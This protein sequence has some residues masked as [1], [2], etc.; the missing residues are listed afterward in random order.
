M[1]H[2]T[3]RATDGAKL[4]AWC[5]EL[6]R[7]TAV[8]RNRDYCKRSC[9]QRAY[10]AR[11]QREAVVAAVASA[12]ARRPAP[13]SSRDEKA[14]PSKSSRDEMVSAGP[15]PVPAPAVPVVESVLPDAWRASSAIPPG[16][17][18]QK[19]RRLLPPPPGRV[20][21]EALSL[22]EADQSQVDE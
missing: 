1:K 14:G 19:R 5:G 20:R 21:G 16:P 8:G 2:E 11:K 12:V 17:S 9:R 13:D 4:C 15:P 7:Q 3:P 6:V 10:E 22:F 18:K